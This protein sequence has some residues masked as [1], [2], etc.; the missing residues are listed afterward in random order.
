MLLR[1]ERVPI[2][3]HIGTSSLPPYAAISW[4]RTTR[5]LHL[6]TTRFGTRC[7]RTSAG[8]LLA[9]ADA[10]ARR[11]TQLDPHRRRWRGSAQPWLTSPAARGRRRR[12]LTASVLLRALHAGYGPCL[13]DQGDQLG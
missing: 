9:T 6:W 1:I 2:F 3:E 4:Q 10:D 8:R 13:I 7:Y 5:A 11:G 12:R